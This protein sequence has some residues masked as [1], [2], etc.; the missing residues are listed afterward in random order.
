[1]NVRA[2]DTNFHVTGQISP[3]EFQPIAKAGY[4]TVVC[5]RPDGRRPPRPPGWKPITFRSPRA[6]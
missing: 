3:A 2:V 4:K 5:M 6:R 1:M